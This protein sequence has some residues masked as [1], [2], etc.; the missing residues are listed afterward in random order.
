[1]KRSVK[2]S[3]KLPA[4]KRRAQLVKAATR[5]FI[6]KGYRWATMDEIARAAGVTKGALYFHFKNKEDLLFAVVKQSWERVSG[7]IY[8]LSETEPSPTALLDKTLR[9]CLED[10]DRGNYLSMGL[11]EQALKIPRIRNYWSRENIR[12]ADALAEALVVKCGI[13]REEALMA[14]KL[15][16]AVIDG[17]IVQRNIFLS[18]QEANRLADQLV[19]LFGIYLNQADKR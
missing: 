17:L 11:L 12:M 3:P 19:R 13:G 9:M 2:Q 8:D 1:M 10:I 14:I 15:L 6:R 4:E 5:L 7:P 18:K 16:D